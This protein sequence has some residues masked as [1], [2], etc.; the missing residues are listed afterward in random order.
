MKFKALSSFSTLLLGITLGSVIAL[1]QTADPKAD[2]KGDKD[3][4]P[5]KTAPKKKPA[6]KPGQPIPPPEKDEDEEEFDKDGNPIKKKPK[7]PVR[8]PIN[9]DPRNKP[10]EE[11][12]DPKAKPTKKKPTK[13]DDPK[14]KPT[15]EDSDPKN[16]KKGKENDSSTDDKADKDS[17]D[18]KKTNKRPAKDEEEEDLD[19][20]PKPQRKRIGIVTPYLS[21]ELTPKI[22]EEGPFE[23]LESFGYSYFASARQA[24]ELRAQQQMN[25]SPLKKDAEENPIEPLKT[26]A[27][28]IQLAANDTIMPAPERYQIGPGDKLSV[29]YSS[30]T[31][32]SVEKKLTVDLSGNINTPIMSTRLTVRGMTLAQVQSSLQKEIRRGLRDAEVTVN[33]SELR[34]ISV[35]IVGEVV[36]Q[37]NY[38]L[39]SVMTLFNALYAA[40]GPTFNGSMRRI[41]LRRSN[42][43]AR[44][45]DLY[46]YLIKGDASQDVPLQPGDL[47]LVPIASNRVAIKGEVERPAVYETAENERVKDLITYAGGSKPTAILD[48]TEIASVQPGVERQINNV[49]LKTSDVNQN[50][51]LKAGD[52][53]TL[54]AVNEEIKNAI[55]VDGAVDQPR[56]YEFT[57]GMTVAD[58]IEKARGLLKNAYGIRAD[59]YRE[60][61]DKSFTLIK[62]DL[63]RALRRDPEAN[64][65]LQRNDTVRVYAT[66]EITWMDDRMVELVGAVRK[67]GKYARMDKMRVS[68][69]L[70][71]GGGLTPEASYAYLFV[72]RRN[73]DG[74]EGPLFKIDV[75]AA[76]A[77]SG[78][79]NIELQDRDTVQVYKVNEAAFIP[80]HTVTILGAIQTAGI[81]PRSNNLTLRDLLTLAGGLVPSASDE[82]QIS[83]ARVLEGTPYDRYDVSDIL[84]GRKNPPIL[85]GDVVTI[86]IDGKLQDKPV[87]VEIKGRVKKPGVYVILSRTETVNDLVAR[88]GGLSDGAWP[89]GAQFLRDPRLLITDAENKLSPRVRSILETIQS[90]EYL[91]ALAKSDIDKI[92]LLNAQSGS[93]GGGIAGLAAISGLGGLGQQQP[94][95]IPPTKEEKDTVEKLLA[96]RE[97]VTPA[98]P[99]SNEE[100]YE[101]G[102]IPIRL[103]EALKSKSSS[104]NIVL[105]DGDMISIPERP[106]TVAVRGAV[107]VPSTILF[108]SNR[109]LGHY[110]DRSGGYTIDADSTQVLV[111]R[112]KGTIT[113]AR[114]NTKIELGD[115]IFVPTRVMVAKLTEGG[116]SGADIFKQITN[117]GL[118]Y[119]I[120]RSIVR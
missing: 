44:T 10:P 34:S 90:Q 57:S 59:V 83:H 106:T 104:S 115:T 114:N 102:N 74:S 8:G 52:I 107:I 85:D 58:A 31:T 91:R 56:S 82:I 25:P 62:I 95:P 103:D 1:G 3:K 45:I 77:A 71:Q 81:Y 97:T 11:K 108:E 68:D 109:T 72:Y 12:E 38:Q 118:L 28:P 105:R 117:L 17:K 48:R 76:L 41:Q 112:A 89:E 27:G 64:I 119:A 43:T 51:R 55:T 65:T 21:Q 49:N 54:Y 92:R 53:V 101:S 61:E 19:Q 29:R 75:R 14:G 120:Y 113:R 7:A 66:E 42:G 70:L 60:N 63:Q 69:L 100:V 110:L 24:V 16:P 23:G 79:Q 26:I 40:G 36:V 67:P 73:A 96:K 98:R 30:P 86:P 4:K 2:P 46:S 37:G 99:L 80:E 5:S 6:T 47:I 39:P 87:T 18:G 111:I 94:A 15:K 20:N 78:D 22:Y 35:S 13:S 33:L 50:P 84:T 116:T 88:A 9:R 93:G 32:A